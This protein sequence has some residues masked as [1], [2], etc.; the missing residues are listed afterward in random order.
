MK[1][2]L[3][4]TI[5]FH[6]EV[7]KKNIA[8]LR[9]KVL[10]DHH[11]QIIAPH[12]VPDFVIKKFINDH[13]NWILSHANKVSSL[14]KLSSLQQITILEEPYKINIIPAHKDAFIIFE[15]EK[16]INIH[17]TSLSESKL[18]TLFNTRLRLYALKTIK[19]E[20][21]AL[22]QTYSFTYGKISVRNQSSRFGSCSSTGNLSFNWQIIFFPI[23][24]FRHILL[25][26]AAHLTHHNHSSSFWK[27]LATYDLNW[28]LNRLWLKQQGSKYFLIHKS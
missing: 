12:L 5:L 2:L 25:H 16:M 19:Q 7:K 24:K 26:E 15:T 3:L 14:P 17:V 13:Q 10:P 9:L 22:S 1:E 21:R 23:D 27:L 11:L 8:S 4:G 6:L 28:R 20:F 18:K